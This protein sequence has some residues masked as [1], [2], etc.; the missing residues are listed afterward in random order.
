M[1]GG[2]F[3]KTNGVALGYMASLT[4]RRLTLDTQ[5]EYLFD[6]SD[7]ESVFLHLVRAQLLARLIGFGRGCGAADKGIPNAARHAARVLAGVSFRALIL[8][9]T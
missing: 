3:G 7:R 5:G 6:V 1:I 9:A 2:V 4:Y 8:A